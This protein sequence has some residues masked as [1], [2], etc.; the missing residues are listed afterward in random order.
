MIYARRQFLLKG[1]D[2]SDIS[3]GKR[4][5]GCR[6]YKPCHVLAA[7]TCVR[8]DE[9]VLAAREA[10]RIMAQRTILPTSTV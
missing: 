5:S 7:V 2:G 10:Y 4:V 1:V 3:P 6:P 8:M 9:R